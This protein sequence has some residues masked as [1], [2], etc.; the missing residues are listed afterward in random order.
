MLSGY[1][2]GGAS[3]LTRYQM[4]IP[5]YTPVV[6]LLVRMT[7]QSISLHSS[8]VTYTVNGNI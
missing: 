5:V 8:F 1:I 6:I 3:H 4:F 2:V 7:F